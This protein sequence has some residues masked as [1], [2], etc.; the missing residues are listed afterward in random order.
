MAAAILCAKNKTRGTILCPKLEAAGGVL[1]K[2]RGLLGR[3]RLEAGE[4]MLFHAGI[5]PIMWM[6]MFFMR[7]AIDIV[8]LDGSGRVLKIDHRLKPWRVSS[9]VLGARRALEVEAGAAAASR[10]EV[11]DEIVLTGA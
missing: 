10:T 4:G 3:D 11:G 7:F 8:F 6:H 1:G 9:L 2:G 5:L